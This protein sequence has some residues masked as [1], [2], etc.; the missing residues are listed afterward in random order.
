MTYKLLARVSGLSL[1]VALVGA[2]AP[3]LA[4]DTGTPVQPAAPAGQQAAVPAPSTI[5]SA[6]PGTGDQGVQD[7]VVTARRRNESIQSTPIA[8]TAISTAQLEAKGTLN[9]G[10]LQGQAPNVIITQ[11]T[12]GPSG[13]NISIRGLAFA[14]I[15]KSFDP[16]VAVVVDGIFIGTSTGQYLDFFDISSIEVLRGPQGTLFGRNT[17]GGVINIA[18]SRPTGEWGGKIEGSYASY[19]TW[20]AKGILNAPIIPG[21]LAAKGFYFHSDSDGYYHNAIRNTRDGGYAND[22]FGVSLLFTPASNFD[23]LLTLEK[24]VQNDQ[25]TNAN[26]AKTGE[27]FCL[28]EPANECNRTSADQLYTVFTSPA[29]SHYASP[30]ATLAM[31]WNLGRIK[32]T[33]ITGYRD[34]HEDQ[35]QDFDASSADLYYTRRQ[36]TYNQFSQELRAAGKIIDNLDYVIGGFYFQSN[37]HIIQDTRLFGGN[38]PPQIASGHAQSYA[39]FADFDYQFLRKFRLSFGGRYTH[40]MKAFENFLAVPLG[41][42]SKSFNKFTPKIGLDYR[43][44]DDVMLYASWSRGYRSGGFSGRSQTVFSTNTPYGPETVDSYEIGTKLSLFDHK[45]LF[46]VDGF[47]ADY[48]NLQ[49]NT[50]VTSPPP[51]PGDETVV[52]NVGSAKIKGIEVDFT[53]R[54][55]HNLRV[56]GSLGYLD[57]KFKG[58]ITRGPDPSR[59][60]PEGGAAPLAAFDYSSNNLI[61]APKLTLSLNGDYT[62]P[63]SFGEGHLN[64]GVRRITPYD[65]QISNGGLILTSTAA[66]GTNSYKVNGNDPRVRTDTQVLADASVSLQFTMGGHKARATVFGRNLSDDRGK[67]QGFTVAGLWSFASAREPRTVGAQLD[68][69]F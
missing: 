67:S 46:N 30:A 11:D 66:D 65:Q 61:Y 8:I 15:E 51:S 22:N 68:F 27:V 43:P 20:S 64:F 28:F 26:I 14:D 32:L 6:E 18:R 69:E 55:T 58:F 42:P 60:A 36:Q 3:A 4:Q 47:Y 2:A 50:T 37:Y 9:I 29:F 49:Q 41:S 7:I 35:T 24:Q 16:T 52:N 31:N 39:G 63:T 48:S 10:D 1:G 34:S 13:A 5:A 19:N 54:P 12:A 44:N 38:L 40:D 59:A 17:I 33:S 56:T 21:V 25:V 53:A 23:A 57:S 45:L 62:V